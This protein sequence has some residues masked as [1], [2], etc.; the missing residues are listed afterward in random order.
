MSFSNDT[1]DRLRGPKTPE[2]EEKWPTNVRRRDI[3]LHRV[4][5]PGHVWTYKDHAYAKMAV[6]EKNSDRVL[7]LIRACIQARNWTKFWDLYNAHTNK[8]GLLRFS[9]IREVATII[10]EGHIDGL[11]IL[12]A[13]A[14]DYY[15][16][17]GVFQLYVSH[18]LNQSP[19]GY[20]NRII[21]FLDE[22]ARLGILNRILDRRGTRMENLLSSTLKRHCLAWILRFLLQVGVR[23]DTDLLLDLIFKSG[24]CCDRDFAYSM[25]ET[26][27]KLIEDVHLN[28]KVVITMNLAYLF[29]TAAIGTKMASWLALLEIPTDTLIGRRVCDYVGFHWCHI[30]GITFVDDIEAQAQGRV[31]AKKEDRIKLVRAIMKILPDQHGEI[32]KWI[33]TR[34][35]GSEFDWIHSLDCDL[36]S[37]PRTLR[38]ISD[39]LIEMDVIH[40]ND[41]DALVRQYYLCP[42]HIENENY[43]EFVSLFPVNDAFRKSIPTDCF[44]QSGRDHLPISWDL[45]SAHIHEFVEYMTKASEIVENIQ[46]PLDVELLQTFSKFPDVKVNNI[47]DFN[48]Q[49]T[50]D[51]LLLYKHWIPGYE[52]FDPMYGLC[53]YKG[54]T[55]TLFNDVWFQYHCSIYDK[56]MKYKYMIEYKAEFVFVQEMKTYNP[57]RRMLLETEK[58]WRCGTYINLPGDSWDQILSHIP[59]VELDTYHAVNTFL[60]DKHIS[61]WSKVKYINIERCR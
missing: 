12:Q 43:P 38:V 23:F 34:F 26:W 45:I 15:R 10:Q 31:V 57:S 30:L 51:L 46:T 35:K 54:V 3:L 29:R 27:K 32:R 41:L 19:D 2:Y 17:E 60:S 11:K 48:D 7:E 52:Y 20:K 55:L 9:V 59:E 36:P 25:M 5:R 16:Y 33:Q 58:P 37:Y 24:G 21:V 22:C 18:S 50:E 1:F 8:V 13:L 14:D 53:K 4:R 49:A 39:F 40:Q 61:I 44:M 56:M 28:D 42:H 6:K 47:S